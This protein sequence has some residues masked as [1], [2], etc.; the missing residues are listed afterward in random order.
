MVSV[1]YLNLHQHIFFASLG[2]LMWFHYL[3]IQQI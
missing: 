2:T 3:N 1:F